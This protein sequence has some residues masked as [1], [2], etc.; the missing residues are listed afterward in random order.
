MQN[1]A[2]MFVATVADATQLHLEEFRMDVEDCTLA[3]VKC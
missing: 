1:H 2:G 3:N